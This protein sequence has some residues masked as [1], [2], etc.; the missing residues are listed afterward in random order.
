MVFLA[1]FKNR[2]T[3][4]LLCCAMLTLGASACNKE[5]LPHQ[6]YT[7]TTAHSPRANHNATLDRF[8]AEPF[9]PEAQV[10]A[11]F[12]EWVN[13]A[14]NTDH[15]PVVREAI[16]TLDDADIERRRSRYHSP[17]IPE[18][19]PRG[20]ELSVHQ[21]LLRRAPLALVQSNGQVQVRFSTIRPIAAAGLYYGTIVPADPFRSHR[22]RRHE[23]NLEQLGEN[24]Y[25]LTGDIRPLLRERYDVGRTTST[26]IGSFAFRVEVLDSTSTEARVFDGIAGFRCSDGNCSGDEV[27]R[28]TP[29]F[30]L[31]PF[32]DLATTD[33]VTLSAQIDVPARVAAAIV[34]PS[35][36]MRVIGGDD[37]TLTPEIEIDGLE[38]DTRYGYQLWA[39]DSQGETRRSRVAAFTTAPRG[40]ATFTFAACSDSRSGH[41]TADDRYAGTNRRVL[42]RLMLESMRHGARFNVFVGDLIDGY[43]TSPAAFRFELFAWKQAVSLF[44]PYL[45]IYEIMG[46]HESLIQKWEP[47]WALAR[48]APNSPEQIFAESFVNPTNAPE[49]ASPNAP[50]YSENTYSFDY[51]QAHFS[52]INSNYW[53]R[54]HPGRSDHPDHGRGQHE[55]W[56]NDT[57][58]AWLDADLSDARTRGQTHL[59]VFTHEPGF[60]NG[61]HSHDGMYYR[62]EIPE[63][64]ARRDELFRLLARHGVT[65]IV[66]GD[67]HNYSRLQIDDSLVSGMSRPV[68][69]LISGGTGAP[70]YAQ[71]RQLPWSNQVAAFDARQHVLLFDVS[72]SQ[73]G[74]RV[75]G[76]MGETIDEAEL[77]P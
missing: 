27:F 71:E 17:P 68:W 64:L 75:I 16:V 76:V 3:P 2:F 74:L 1:I 29:S 13:A 73:V 41:G 42:E 30:A 54:S 38:P 23:T 24:E 28:Q 43:T 55:G 21:R 34:T 18:G 26:G 11:A 22:Y 57:T 35:G 33:S 25:Q 66:H 69:Q 50:T 7:V 56:I 59:F 67:E 37:M 19:S 45:P 6:E 15:P 46:N 36:E 77:T 48:P 20:E 63:V 65:A 9:W 70:Y 32:V 47:G 5:I 14:A 52:V 10:D 60:P 4:A 44:S 61:G 53:Y 40:P 31:G 72:E 51:A 49:P 8:V 58:L 12:S 62:G 39:R